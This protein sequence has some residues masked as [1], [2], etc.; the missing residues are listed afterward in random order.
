MS[1]SGSGALRD[2]EGHQWLRIAARPHAGIWKRLNAK[3]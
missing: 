1:G 3:L 2:A